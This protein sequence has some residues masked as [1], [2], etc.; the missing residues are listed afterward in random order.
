MSKKNP[1][2]Q[3]EEISQEFDAETTKPVATSRK[4]KKADPVFESAPVSEPEEAQPEEGT[5]KDKPKK[6][7]HGK[8]VW[9]GIL[10]MIVLGAIG[11]G[12]GYWQ[13]MNARMKAEN[14]MRLEKAAMHFVMAEQ[15]QK[16]GDLNMAWQRL[17]YVLE[18][19]PQYPG[20]ED[21]LAEV[22]LALSLSQPQNTTTQEAPVTVVTA[23]PTKDTTNLSILLQQAQNQLKT[24]QQQ[25]TY[26]RF[27]CRDLTAQEGHAIQ[28]WEALLITVNQMRNLDPFY[29]SV[30]V[31]GLYYTALRN[32][33]MAYINSGKLE[34]GIYYLT[35]AETIAPLDYEADSFKYRARTIL[36]AGSWYGVNW[37]K[38]TDGFY[39]ILQ[40][41]PNA[42]DLSCKTVKQLYGSSLEGLGDTYMMSGMSLA[43]DYCVAGSQ[44]RA[45]SGIISSD[46]LTQK[47]QLADAYCANPP[48]TPT[49][50]ADPNAPTPTPPP[51][52]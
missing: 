1:I 21:K 8:W 51:T 31:D 39:E 14:E 17:N 49:P 46:A 34:E 16:N 15:D 9:L 50:T 28:P 18:I 12:I 42:V 48:P 32:N 2:E 33:G 7:R 36:I 25:N 44:Y 37:Q 52:E 13:A 45:A 35:E 19:Y 20:L 3:P 6:V 11:T 43:S 23:V 4:A 47:I 10:I 41:F 24:A 22:M 29:E 5:K 26:D 40:N 38:A 27:T 30:K